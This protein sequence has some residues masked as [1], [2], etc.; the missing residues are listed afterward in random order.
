MKYLRGELGER[1]FEEVN[2]GSIKLRFLQGIV[3]CANAT[4]SALPSPPW[5]LRLAA[6][7]VRDGDSGRTLSVE[8]VGK[9]RRF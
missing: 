8:S 4:R 6:V 5:K 2:G 3:R 9:L 1:K 7:T